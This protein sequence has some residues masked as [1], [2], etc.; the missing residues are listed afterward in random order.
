MGAGKAPVTLKS[1]V[2][3]RNQRLRPSLTIAA[4]H[5]PVIPIRT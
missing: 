2:Y 4:I 3:T 1:I 5:V